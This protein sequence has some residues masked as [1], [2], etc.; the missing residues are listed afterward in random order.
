MYGLFFIRRPEEGG[1]TSVRVL[2]QIAVPDE[3]MRQ[4]Q[5]FARSAGFEGVRATK[6]DLGH[7]CS[8]T[9]TCYGDTHVLWMAYV[10]GL[11]ECALTDELQQEEGIDALARG[12]A[13]TEVTQDDFF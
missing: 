8:A 10:P 13:V 5:Q 7:F 11:D 6:A 9:V 2:P 4:L 12:R 3:M 1:R